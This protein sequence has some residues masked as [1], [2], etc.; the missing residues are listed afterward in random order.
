M[1]RPLRASH[2]ILYLYSRLPG[3]TE[4]LR[5]NWVVDQEDSQPNV[6]IAYGS[7]SR[8]S[9]TYQP[10]VMDGYTTPTPHSRRN[11]AARHS[12]SPTS[13]SPLLVQSPQ[14]STSSSGSPFSRS[15]VNEDGLGEP[16]TPTTGSSTPI[17]DSDYVLRS[18]ESFE[19]PRNLAQSGLTLSGHLLRLIEHL[20]PHIDSILAEKQTDEQVQVGD[21]KNRRHSIA[22]KHRRMDHKALSEIQSKMCLHVLRNLEAGKQDRFALA[23]KPVT[24]QAALA[25]NKKKDAPKTSVILAG[26]LMMVNQETQIEALQSELARVEQ[27]YDRM[28][29]RVRQLESLVE[30]RSS[31]RNY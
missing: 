26:I 31:S 2:L 19:L 12:T 18:S 13:P 5:R 22:E 28:L 4:M 23:L 7:N 10:N 16:S 14:L 6:A 11:A 20:G 3:I 24:M 27:E 9:P 15:S 25:K 17:A 29:Q 30:G 8:S 1:I 21:D